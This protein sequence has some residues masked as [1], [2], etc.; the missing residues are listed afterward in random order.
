MKVNFIAMMAGIIAVMSLVPLTAAPQPVPAVPSAPALTAEQLDQLVAPI[1]LY[2]DPLVAQIMM[3]A[4]YPLEV[5][6]A[7]RWLNIPAN[8]ALKRD[9]LTAALQQQPWDPSVKSIVSFPQLL[10]MMDRNLEWT[11]QLGDAFL[12]QQADI[13]DAVQRLRQRAETAGSLAS[14]PQ[15]TISTQDQEI[16]IEPASPDIVY[17]PAY[18]P[19][20]V[21]GPWPYVAYTPFD[22]GT[23][24]G[25]CVPADA[26]LAFDVGIYPPLDFWA[27]GS[28]DWRRHHIRIDHDRFQR[29]HSRHEPPGGIWQHDPI[30]RHGVPYRDPATAARFLGPAA[31]VRRDFRGF[32]PAPAAVPKTTAVAP[33]VRRAPAAVGRPSVAPAAPLRPA[34]PAFESFGH[35]AQIRGEAARGFSSRMAPAPSISAAPAPSFHAAPA[36]S[37]HAAPAPVFHG[38]GGGV[39]R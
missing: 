16:T 14:T 3:A 34:P 24:P 21:Y 8:T 12:A 36:P 38:G 22:F 1:A 26:I 27:W 35:G 19:W 15:Q 33:S 6:E 5:V 28:F 23:W 29:F 2:P 10:H 4:T 17:I 13:M 18:N 37:F 30:H 9:T 11:E 7:D 31:A 39:R 32:A 25:Y 20:C